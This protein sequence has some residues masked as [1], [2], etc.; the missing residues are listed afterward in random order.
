MRAVRG[1]K[2]A[3]LQ[4]AVQHPAGVLE[5]RLHQSGFRY[6]PGQYLFLNC[7]TVARHEW[8]PMTITSSPDDQFVSVHIARAGDW[9]GAVHDLINPDQQLG[10]APPHRRSCC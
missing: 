6:K 2:S 5:L 8:H 10:A 9:T 7:P 1:R 4:C 3:V